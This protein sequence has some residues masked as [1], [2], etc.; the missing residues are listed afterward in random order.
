M[1]AQ[2]LLDDPDLLL[3]RPGPTTPRVLNRQ[4]LKIGDDLCACHKACSYRGT[5]AQS[6]GR[7][8]R[9]TYKEPPGRHFEGLFYEAAEVARCVTAGKLE[10]NYRPL[11]STLDAMTTLDMIRQCIGIRFAEAGLVE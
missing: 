7:R 9:D 10:T 5:R 2:A 6:D 8:R 3:V 11:Q 4:K 1:A